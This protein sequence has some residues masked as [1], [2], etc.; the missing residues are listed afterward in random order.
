MAIR[1]KGSIIIPDVVGENTSSGITSIGINAIKS[2]TTGTHDVAVGLNALTSNTV[3]SQNIAIGSNSLSAVVAGN[4]NIGIGYNAGNLIVNG[5]NNTVIGNLTPS[6]STNDTVL[7][8]AGST[9]RIKVDSSG[10][11]ING[12]IFAGGLGQSG[13]SGVSGYSG[14]GGLSGYSGYSGFSGTS[15]ANGLSGYSGVS[16]YSGFSGTSGFG[17]LSGYSGKAGP[18]NVINATNQTTGNYYVVGVADTGSD[19]TASASK[20]APLYF[21]ASIGKIFGVISTATNLESG[22]AGSIPYQSAAGSTNFL[23]LS[24]TLYS[25]L[26]ADT[27]GPQYITQVQAKNGIASATQATGQSLVVTGG[28]IGVTG[29]SY[30]ANDVGISGNQVVGNTLQV[31]STSSNTGTNTSNALYV[32]GG[33]WVSKDFVVEGNTT[34]KGQVVIQATATFAASTVTIYTD[35]LIEIHSNGSPHAGWT[36]DDGKDVGHIYHYYNASADRT[37]FL[38]LAN[39]TKYLEWY[40]DGTEVGGVFTGTSYG[41]FKTGDIKLVSG[42]AATSTQTGDLQVVGGVGIGGDMHVGGV[43]YFG[44]TPSIVGLANPLGV[45]TADQNNYV[46][47]QIQNLSTGSNASSDFIATADNGTDGDHYIDVGI[48]NGGYSTST[49][50]MSGANDGYLYVNS[51]DLTVGTDTAGKKLKVHIGGT[52]ADN[53]VAT[54]NAKN[55]DATTSAT[56][57]LV[58]AGG[59][60]VGGN[61][62]IGGN[63]TFETGLYANATQI[64]DSSGNW[65][66]PAISSV[67]SVSETAPSLPVSGNLWW[68]SSTSSGVLKIYYVDANT[69]QWVDAV[70]MSASSGSTS[71]A[72]GFEQQFL[73]MGA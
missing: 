63:V 11:Y 20:T 25:V 21:D 68:N 58:V 42:T 23:T 5:S 53:V 49:W 2:L 47:V 16:G 31:L 38:G 41:T 67:V 10:L 36:V 50:T 17:G 19:Q 39:D 4:N 9:E 54:F 7:I 69:G 3:G 46:Q 62:R 35:N 70:P 57:T 32:A 8:G 48:N 66:G 22:T 65:V 64:I 15:G 59:V 33:A 43:A 28:G 73:L 24:S 40:N 14:Y 12:V 37:G 52:L 34:F 1:I 27:T 60:G 56:G 18:S 6:S 45:F 72:G 13:Y 61:A 44:P 51:G 26:A 30:F 71:S 55:T 29:S